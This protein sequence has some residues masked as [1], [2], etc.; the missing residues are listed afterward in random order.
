MEGGESSPAAQ[1]VTGKAGNTDDVDGKDCFR[2]NVVA[3]DGLDEP[4]IC[5]LIS[6]YDLMLRMKA[7]VAKE[8][9][10]CVIVVNEIHD[11]GTVVSND[12]DNNNDNNNN[13]PNT[14]HI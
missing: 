8:T 1:E 13:Y 2:S 6:D 4:R 7:K 3:V 9:H 12:N 5:E 14:N 10:T 11:G